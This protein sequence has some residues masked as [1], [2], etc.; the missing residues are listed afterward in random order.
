M[1]GPANGDGPLPG[2][3]G[4]THGF[5]A[6]VG[7][8]KQ[9]AIAFVPEHVLRKEHQGFGQGDVLEGLPVHT[10][11]ERNLGGLLE[12]LDAF[13]G[14]GH[15]VLV[16]GVDSFG[17]RTPCGGQGVYQGRTCFVR[18]GGLLFHIFPH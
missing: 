9:P 8:Q 6:Q 15:V 18:H 16:Q 3:D 14:Q 2:L 11:G 7:A 5:A 17:C 4:N 1:N 13:A 12:V 10:R